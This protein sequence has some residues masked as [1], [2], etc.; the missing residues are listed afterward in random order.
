MTACHQNYNADST[1]RINMGE[2]RR[3]LNEPIL[4]QSYTIAPSGRS[5]PVKENSGFDAS[6]NGIAKS[7]SVQKLGYSSQKMQH[8]RVLLQKMRYRNQYHSRA[9]R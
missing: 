8:T 1:S 3:S 4:A 2:L 6:A 9:L 7:L 5:L